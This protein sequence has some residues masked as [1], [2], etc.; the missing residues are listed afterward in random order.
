MSFIPQLPID[1]SA[2]MESLRVHLQNNVHAGE[3]VLDVTLDT[4]S[5][6]MHQSAVLMN[7]ELLSAV[8]MQQSLLTAPTYHHA[9]V[10]VLDHGN[11]LRNQYIKY[12]D[13]CFACHH[14][15]MARLHA[16]SGNA[17]H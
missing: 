6:F 13:E 15:A 9:W 11:R 1:P 14:R 7:G 12:L 8:T 17:D 4:A 2:V 16:E 3:R 5:D 10:A